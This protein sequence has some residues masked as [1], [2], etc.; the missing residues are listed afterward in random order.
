VPNLKTLISVTGGS[1]I[2]II[3]LTDKYSA[4]KTVQQSYDALRAPGTLFLIFIF[5]GEMLCEQIIC[6]LV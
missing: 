1:K 4:L 6:L 5:A 3:N 2:N